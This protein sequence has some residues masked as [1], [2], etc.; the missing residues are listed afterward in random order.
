[1]QRLF[2]FFFALI[3][4]ILL[5]PLFLLITFI[6]FIDTGSPFFTQK[7]V[8]RHKRPFTIIK[9][10]TMHTDTKSVPTHLANTASITKAG[11]VLRRSKL[12]ELPQLLNVLIGDMSLVGPR[13][14]LVDQTELIAAREKLNVFHVRPGITGLSQIKKID[15][16]T[17]RELAHCDAQ[18]LSSLNLKNYFKFILLTLVGAGSG[19]AI[20]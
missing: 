19:D 13:P 14:G 17:P 5:S 10:R 9:F 18:M 20:H 6:G 1:M 7:R 11:N 3:G 15:M 4:L 2:D 8:G 16:S 12:D